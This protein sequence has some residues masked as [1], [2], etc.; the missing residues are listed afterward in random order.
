MDDYQ[1]LTIVSF[2][3]WCAMYQT[4]LIGSYLEM[5]SYCV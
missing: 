4:S 1:R 3:M 5:L 2:A